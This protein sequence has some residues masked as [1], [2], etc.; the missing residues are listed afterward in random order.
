MFLM[1]KHDANLIS[2]LAELFARMY[3]NLATC[4]DDV[5]EFLK[6]FGSLIARPR[7]AHVA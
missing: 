7:S 6:D 3:I 1:L 2:S 4:V 5:F